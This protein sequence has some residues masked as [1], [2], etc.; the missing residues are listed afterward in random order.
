MLN[1]EQKKIN[2][3]ICTTSACE[4]NHFLWRRP[5]VVPLS[6]WLLTGPPRGGATLLTQI[7]QLRQCQVWEGKWAASCCE[8]FDVTV[9]SAVAS[10]HFCRHEVGSRR[11]WHFC[12]SEDGSRC[13]ISTMAQHCS[14]GDR[15]NSSK[16]SPNS[17]FR[18]FSW[19][20]WQKV[21]K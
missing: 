11:R 4:Q 19:R 7:R 18:V 2:A 13:R 20:D 14:L 8:S 12:G 5:G 10:L 9:P 6:L 15:V 21:L 1:Y 16:R 17:L 3:R